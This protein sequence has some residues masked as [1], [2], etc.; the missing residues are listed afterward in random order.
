MVIILV[1]S[2]YKEF[3]FYAP[4]N[5][6]INNIDKEHHYPDLMD[7]EFTAHDIMASPR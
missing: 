1:D 2:T 6:K 3:F 7:E 4:V 5:M